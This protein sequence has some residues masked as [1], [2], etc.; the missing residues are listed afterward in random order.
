MNKEAYK[1]MHE[2][3]LAFADIE[4]NGIRV[5]IPYYKR[6]RLMIKEQIRLLELELDRTEEV[7]TW[8]QVYKEK[9][10]IDSN[11]QLSKVLFTHLEIEPPTLT[12][13]GNPSVDKDSLHLIDSPIVQPLIQLRQL[14][15]L[16]NTYIKN[17]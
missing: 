11:P 13:K 10:N 4:Q 8:R 7:K 6:Q 1:L 12:A 2:G 5:D 9:F 14:K 15:K 16:R 3:T 17:I